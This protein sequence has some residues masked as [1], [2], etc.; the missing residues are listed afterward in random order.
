M[1]THA[2]K[3][4]LNNMMPSTQETQGC[5]KRH[6]LAPLSAGDSGE[7]AT[8]LP[9]NASALR[10]DNLKQWKTQHRKYSAGDLEDWLPNNPS[11]PLLLLGSNNLKISKR[12]DL[13]NPGQ[14]LCP[15]Q[16]VAELH[17]QQTH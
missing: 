12:P 15:N 6:T 9:H 14:H 11:L 10:S 16:W 7:M 1:G 4:S 13:C 2:K 8:K 3:T 5:G 17:S